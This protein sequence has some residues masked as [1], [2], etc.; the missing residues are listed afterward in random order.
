MLN[1]LRSIT[2]VSIVKVWWLDF[3][4]SFHDYVNLLTAEFFLL[5]SNWHGDNFFAYLDLARRFFFIVTVGM[6]FLVL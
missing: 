3:H 1:R 4:D 2:A 6:D 5:P